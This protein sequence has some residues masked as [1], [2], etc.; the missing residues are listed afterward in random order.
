MH[1][2]QTK[3]G[4]SKVEFRVGIMHTECSSTQVEVGVEVR[5]PI[6]QTKVGSF[7][8]VEVRVGIWHTE[9][10]FTQVEVGVGIIQTQVGV[11]MKHIEEG[12]CFQNI[13]M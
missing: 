9:C 4:S 3:V 11:G 8:Q 6:R 10:S 12:F 2:R 13:H 5:V 1:I 7:P